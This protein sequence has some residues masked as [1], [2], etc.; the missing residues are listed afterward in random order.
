MAVAPALAEAGRRDL[1]LPHPRTRR[2]FVPISKGMKLAALG[3]RASLCIPIRS[4][5][6]RVFVSQVTANQGVHRD[7]RIHHLVAPPH[8][9]LAVGF[10]T[11]TAADPS[12]GNGRGVPNRIP[13]GYGSPRAWTLRRNLGGLV[14][15]H[16]ST[17]YSV[18]SPTLKQASHQDILYRSTQI[19]P[20]NCHMM[21]MMKLYALLGYTTYLLGTVLST[22]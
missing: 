16:L 8:R 1:A 3:M 20:K 10:R 12:T 4:L 14:Y 18:V 5:P 15:I 11:A 22:M 9:D 17:I 2:R 13:G 21:M 7:R 19:C 6:P